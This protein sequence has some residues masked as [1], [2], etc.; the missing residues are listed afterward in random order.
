MWCARL[1]QICQTRLQKVFQF[2]MSRLL[3]SV[4]FSCVVL[5]LH[6]IT[7][8]VDDAMY[9]TLNSLQAAGKWQYGKLIISQRLHVQMNIFTF[10]PGTDSRFAV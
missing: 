2:Q 6:C 10:Y 4:L 5:T 1:V 9:M 3:S 8:L 7:A